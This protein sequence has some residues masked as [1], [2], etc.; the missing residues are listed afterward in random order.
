[1]NLPDPTCTATRHGTSYA[2]QHYGC[3]CAGIVATMRRYWRGTRKPYRR[4]GPFR[5]G[6][7]R[8]DVDPVAVTLVVNDGHRM[9]LTAGERKAAVAILT[10]RGLMPGQIAD[11][12]GVS[13]RT[14][15]RLKAA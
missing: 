6:S 10:Q 1:M 13:R 14:I 5:A 9:P 15:Q 2:Y 8:L 11:R 7:R 4:N 3:R 12:L